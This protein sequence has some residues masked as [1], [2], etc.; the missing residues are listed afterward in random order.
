MNNERYSI[1]FKAMMTGLFVGVI[2]TVICLVF[3]IVYRNETGYI[4]SSLINVSSLIFA[5]NLMLTL[6]GILFFFFLKAFKKGD[7]LFAI[8]A[9]ALTVWLTWKVT[10]LTRFGDPGLDGGFRGLLG[11]L[12]VILGLSTASIPFLYRSRRFIDAVI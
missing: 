1:F 7:I 6:F 10:G 11:G 4:P 9:V 8:L 3:N 5:I 2:D 12:T